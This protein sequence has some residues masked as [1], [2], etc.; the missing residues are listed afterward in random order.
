MCLF[1]TILPLQ[2][3]TDIPLFC[4]RHVGSSLP[5]QRSVLQWFRG[6]CPHFCQISP[7]LSQRPTGNSRSAGFR[8]DSEVIQR[9]EIAGSPVKRAFRGV[10]PSPTHGHCPA[11]SLLRVRPTPADAFAPQVSQVP[12]ATFQTRRPS[13]PRHA[14]RAAN[15]LRR[16]FS[17]SRSM[18]RWPH[19][20]LGLTRLNSKGSLALR[21]TCL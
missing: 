2:S 3:Q 20:V 19:G 21:L 1:C 5:G 9:V 10:R 11:S 12:D 8:P 4:C 15:R 13:M 18:T 14:F 16:F 7:R 17:A 6:R